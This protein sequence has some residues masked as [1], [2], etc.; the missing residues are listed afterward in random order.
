MIFD[1]ISNQEF[2]HL[3]LDTFIIILLLFR[4]VYNTELD[5]S[6]MTIKEKV[7]HYLILIN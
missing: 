3:H 2:V 6:E 1:W 5:I 4:I 7:L